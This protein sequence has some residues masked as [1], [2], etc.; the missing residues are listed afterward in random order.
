MNI[1][2]STSL[3][4]NRSLQCQVDVSHVQNID[5][6]WIVLNKFLKNLIKNEIKILP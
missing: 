4:A 2:S 6:D 1:S 5:L 3:I